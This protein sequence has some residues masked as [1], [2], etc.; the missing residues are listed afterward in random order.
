[1]SVLKVNTFVEKSAKI[2]NVADFILGKK[3][4]VKD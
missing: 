1:M 4:E 2:L 3:F